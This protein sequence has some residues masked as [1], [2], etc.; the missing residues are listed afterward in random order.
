MQNNTF[1]YDSFIFVNSVSDHI[2]HSS[3]TT[4][5]DPV[6]LHNAPPPISYSLLVMYF[7]GLVSFIQVVRWRDYFARSLLE[8]QLM[9]SYHFVEAGPAPFPLIPA[10]PSKVSPHR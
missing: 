9:L 6:T 3:P 10:R 1:Y 7:G 5:T 2:P 8:S 4:P